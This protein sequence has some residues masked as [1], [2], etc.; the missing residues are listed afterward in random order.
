[1]LI[2]QKLSLTNQPWQNSSYV[3]YTI[4]SNWLIIIVDIF[5]YQVGPSIFASNIGSEHFLELP[6]RAALDGIAVAIYEIQVRTFSP[7]SPA[8]KSLLPTLNVLGLWSYQLQYYSEVHTMGPQDFTCKHY[9]SKNFQPSY[10]Q[11][12]TKRMKKYPRQL[13]AL[14][15]SLFES[16]T[17]DFF[18]CRHHLFSQS[19]DTSSYRSTLLAV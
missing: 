14:I 6:S 16:K 8:T 5:L 12:H 2:R 15:R 13:K 17:E 11:P 3:C 19:W 4:I 10:Q 18:I 7:I 1:M 9:L